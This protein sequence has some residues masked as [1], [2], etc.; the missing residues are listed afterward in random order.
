MVGKEEKLVKTGSVK[1]VFNR[2]GL[3]HCGFS[4][5]SHHELLPFRAKKLDTV[6]FKL[7]QGLDVISQSL[8]S[9]LQIGTTAAS[10]KPST[11]AAR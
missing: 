8:L 10:F 3:R 1:D 9:L 5:N 7:L 4:F 6:L 2:F 11:S